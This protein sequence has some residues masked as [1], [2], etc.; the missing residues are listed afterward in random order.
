M[1]MC[2]QLGGYRLAEIMGPFGLS[3]I[4]SVNFITTQI[5]KRIKES[6]KFSQPMQYAKQHIIKHAF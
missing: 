2:Q 6:Q 3:N 1:L 5:R 4:G